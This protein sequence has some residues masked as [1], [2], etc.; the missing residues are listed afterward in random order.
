VTSVTCPT[1]Q[2]APQAAARHDDQQQTETDIEACESRA[3]RAHQAHRRTFVKH[4]RPTKPLTSKAIMCYS[5]YCN[6]N[7]TRRSRQ[8]DTCHTTE[9]PRD[10]TNTCS[11][12]KSLVHKPRTFTAP[13]ITPGGWRVYL[14]FVCL[15]LDYLG[16][17]GWGVV[18]FG[19]GSW[20]WCWWF[21]FLRFVGFIGVGCGGS[22]CPRFFGVLGCLVG[23]CGCV[24]CLDGF[25]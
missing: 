3:C 14:A 18:G 19:V 1:G 10:N 9:P 4:Q 22:V 24:R 6:P 8:C 16:V 11:T 13:P 12:I 21:G 17:G 20:G 2:R 5:A 15:G 25:G 7:G 23:L